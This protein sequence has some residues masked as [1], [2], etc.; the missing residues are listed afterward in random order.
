VWPYNRGTT[1][2]HIYMD[3]IFFYCCN[4]HGMEY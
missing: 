2:Y 3:M 1:V 4:T